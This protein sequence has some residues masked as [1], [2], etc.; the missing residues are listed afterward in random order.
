C[1]LTSAETKYVLENS[2]AHAILCDDADPAELTPALKGLSLKFAASID[3]AAEGFVSWDELMAT[4]PAQPRYATGNPPLILYTSGTTGLPKGV[5]MG[6][7][8]L[9]DPEARQRL[10]EYQQSVAG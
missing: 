7:P 4:A 2:A 6:G 9:E 3:A 8:H 5:V 1:R 10:I